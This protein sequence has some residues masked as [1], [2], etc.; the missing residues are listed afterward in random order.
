MKKY[1]NTYLILCFSY[2]LIHPT[3]IKVF[4]GQGKIGV[5]DYFAITPIIES[6][7]IGLVFTI[8]FNF[9]LIRR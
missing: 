9:L 8:I 4:V 1:L 6:F 7:L 2:W 5:N 3:I